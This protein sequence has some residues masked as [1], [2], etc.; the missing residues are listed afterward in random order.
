MKRILKSR[1][2]LVLPLAIIAMLMAGG[3]AYYSTQVIMDAQAVNRDI[4]LASYA[5]RESENAIAYGLWAANTPSTEHAN[6]KKDSS[7]TNGTAYDITLEDGCETRTV[8]GYTIKRIV[9]FKDGKIIGKAE[10]Y[11]PDNVKLAE[12]TS[13][14]NIDL[15]SYP[16]KVQKDT[17]S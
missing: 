17:L 6:G 7:F 10:I 14:M 9:Q 1:K 11:T 8:E 15:T 4:N 12:A 16:L 13:S 5:K 3:V 2:G